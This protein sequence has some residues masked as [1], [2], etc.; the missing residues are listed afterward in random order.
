VTVQSFVNLLDSRRVG[1]G[2]WQARCPAHDDRSPSLSI[3]EGRDGRA[4][5]RC[6]A[7]CSLDAILMAMGLTYKDLF[8][9]PPPSPAELAAIQRAREEREEAARVAR[10]MRRNAWDRVRRW[11]AIVSAL[12]AKLAC[13]PDGSSE[14]D[15]LCRLYHEACDRLHAAEIEAEKYNTD[16]RM[17]AA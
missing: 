12:G 5:V 11:E 3:C 9:G 10:M 16:R 17:G 15:R 8:A 4:L 7:G 1:A 13:A 6:F 14:G 2:R